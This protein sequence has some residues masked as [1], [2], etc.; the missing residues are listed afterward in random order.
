M[1][2][3]RVPILF[4][5]LVASAIAADEISCEGLGED[6]QLEPAKGNREARKKT[7]GDREFSSKNPYM[8]LL[9]P[10]VYAVLL[11]YP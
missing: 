9:N 2:I 11:V 5:F 3:R 1:F 7:A 6:N 8:R 4:L 10:R